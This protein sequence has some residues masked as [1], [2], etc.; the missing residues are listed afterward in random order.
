LLVKLFLEMD[1]ASRMSLISLAGDIDENELLNYIWHA[2]KA[3]DDQTPIPGASHSVI[4]GSKQAALLWIAWVNSDSLR[5]MK[6]TGIPVGLIQ[7]ALTALK[8]EDGFDAYFTSL[9]SML[10]KRLPTVDTPKKVAQTK[11][12]PL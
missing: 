8:Q 6:Q 1:Q 11:Q 9:S 7:S 2:L 3:I 4:R 12:N 5:N 10:A